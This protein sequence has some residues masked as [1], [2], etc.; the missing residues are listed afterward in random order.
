MSSAGFRVL[1]AREPREREGVGG[2][3]QSLWDDS[4][5]VKVP[6][7]TNSPAGQ[8]RAVRMSLDKLVAGAKRRLKETAMEWF[9]SM[10]EWWVWLAAGAVGAVALAAFASILQAALDLEAR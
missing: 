6:P 8:L 7:P 9:A 5:R 4:Y 3:R 2:Q 1:H 10:P